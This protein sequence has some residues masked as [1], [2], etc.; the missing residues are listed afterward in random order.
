MTSEPVSKTEESSEP[1]TASVDS[2]E[3]EKSTKS[4]ENP[5]TPASTETKASAN[6]AKKSTP[7]KEQSDVKL[8]PTYEVLPTTARPVSNANKVV[9]TQQNI[10]PATGEDIENKTLFSGVFT[11]MSLGLGYIINR[12]RQS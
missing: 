10:L 11:L 3:V 1:T 2:S 8:T 12:K 6:A 5:S 7:Q 4:A 9:Q